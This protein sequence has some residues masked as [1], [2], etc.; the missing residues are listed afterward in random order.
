MTQGYE[1]HRI[2]RRDSDAKYILVRLDY[3][4]DSNGILTETSMYNIGQDDFDTYAEH[5]DHLN[6]LR[7][8]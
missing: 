3:T 8:L 4:F 5:V 7:G 2:L 1:E 6:H